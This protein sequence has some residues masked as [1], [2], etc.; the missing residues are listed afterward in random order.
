MRSC[1]EICLECIKEGGPFTFVDVGAMG[2]IPHKWKQLEGAM[3]VI[4]FEPDE[5]AFSKLEKRNGI[6]WYNNALHSKSDEL[7]FYV[8]R[9]PGKSSVFKP[10]FRFLSGFEDASRFDTVDRKVFP[11]EKVKCLDD[12]MAGNRIGDVDFVKIDVQ[13]NELAILEGSRKNVLPG[14]FG[15]QLEVEFAGLYEKQPLFR[16]VDRFLSAEGFQ[17]M[18]ISR[19]YWKRKD[20]YDYPGKGQLTF[21]DALYFKTAEGMQTQ[22]G[23]LDAQLDLPSKVYKSII[24]CIVYGMFDYAMFLVNDAVQRQIIQLDQYQ[25]IKDAIVWE[26][27]KGYLPEFW[28]KEFICKVLNRL[29]E[30]MGRRSYLGWADRDRMIGNVRDL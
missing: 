19:C 24:T 6:R 20:Y 15:I 5:R 13:G 3:K 16:D 30:K 14:L 11:K 27:R 25:L 10:D 8:S 17:L 4:A 22:W 26:S 29:L 7:A 1:L 12:I 2:G 21:G 18:D 28:G 23:S 9:D